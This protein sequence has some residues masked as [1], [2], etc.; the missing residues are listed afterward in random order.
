MVIRIHPRASLVSAVAARMSLQ[1]PFPVIGSSL[2]RSG[3]IQDV[4][5]ETGFRSHESRVSLRQMA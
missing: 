1:V 3:R 4:P 2:P 5:F